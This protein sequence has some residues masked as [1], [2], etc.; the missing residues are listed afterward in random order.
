MTHTPPVDTTSMADH[1]SGRHNG[2]PQRHEADS[3]PIGL[4]RF[5]LQRDSDHTGVS[6]TGIVA[7]GVVFPDGV[8]VIRWTGATP[9]SVVFHDRGLESI[10]AV[11]GHG[12]ATRI[13]MVDA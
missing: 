8:A 13:V 4:R 1:P 10:E 5:Y 9:T 11:H 6:G 3:A 2:P 7:T 12:G